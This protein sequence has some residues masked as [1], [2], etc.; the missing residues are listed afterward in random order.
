MIFT[1]NVMHLNNCFDK[2]FTH[3]SL[4]FFDFIMRSTASMNLSASRFVL[5]APN[6]ARTAPVGNVPSVLCASGAQ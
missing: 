1:I 3:E 4:Y 5:N 2:T 6:D